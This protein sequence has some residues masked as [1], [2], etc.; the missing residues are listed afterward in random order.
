MNE[1]EEE[2]GNYQTSFGQDQ[3]LNVAHYLEQKAQEKFKAI[4]VDKQDNLNYDLGN[5]MAVDPTSVDLKLFR[6]NQKDY[7]QK[8]GRE[9]TQL[10]INKIFSL[11]S[12]RIDLGVMV[13]L[14][15]ST[16]VVPRAK[17]LPKPKQ[18]TKW[19]EFAKKKG[20]QKRKRD[21][22]VYDEDSGE[23]KA[24]WG[25]KRINDDEDLQVM[26]HSNKIPE[27][28]DPWEVAREDK[29]KNVTKN[30]KQRKSNLG[31]NSK[32]QT[33]PSTVSLTN[34]PT[35]F[36]RHDK[37]DVQR[38]LQNVQVSTA[39]LGRFDKKLDGEDKIK[40]PSKKIHD[41]VSR[42]EVVHGEKARNMKL[43]DKILG[44]E[45]NVNLKKATNIEQR[46]QESERRKRKA[47]GPPATKSSKGGKRRR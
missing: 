31:K 27:G 22:M 7:I 1:N 34:A 16:T 45:G 17:P 39:S 23:Y 9:N 44:G 3:P 47:Q 2:E 42:G 6:K 13:S 37:E 20:I 10:L 41:S 24:R 19:E 28:S 5:L 40:K 8:V 25:Y 33:L 15:E 46:S 14:P 11:P 38:S 32:Q 26:P 29:K 35:H 21:R 4:R 36:R 30:E 43:L 18:P 12:E